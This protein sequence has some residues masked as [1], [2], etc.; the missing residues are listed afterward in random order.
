MPD[1][2]ADVSADGGPAFP[3]PFVVEETRKGERLYVNAIDA[4]AGGMSLRDW[5]AGQAIEMARNNWSP[6]M[7]A[8]DLDG[9]AVMSDTDRRRMRDQIA[10]DCYSFADAMLAER[11]KARP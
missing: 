2:V 11:A 1:V 8:E 4:G 9:L 5:F 7:L 6:V 3:L 10:A